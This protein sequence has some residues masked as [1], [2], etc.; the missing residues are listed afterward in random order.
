MLITTRGSALLSFEP[1]R[2][3]E[4]K[5]TELLIEA[6][7]SETSVF[8]RCL[9]NRCVGSREEYVLVCPNDGPWP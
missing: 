6:P 1:V 8:Q 9:P 3:R 2:L 7:S 4:V 5:S